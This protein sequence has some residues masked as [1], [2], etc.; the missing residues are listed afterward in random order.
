MENLPL[1][2]PETFPVTW[3][4]GDLTG[5]AC[6]CALGN[7]HFRASLVLAESSPRGKEWHC[8]TGLRRFLSSSEPCLFLQSFQVQFP[9]HNSSSSPAIICESRSKGS[10]SVFWSPRTL[11]SCGAHRNVQARQHY[12]YE[13]KIPLKNQTTHTSIVTFCYMH[14]TISGT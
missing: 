5:A 11:N 9:S 2:F 4:R 8:L 10:G 13:I 12:R 1:G 14:L 7:M 3:L 6:L